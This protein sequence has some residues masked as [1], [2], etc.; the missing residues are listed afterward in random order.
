MEDS[1]I[2]QI[3]EH[4]DQSLKKKNAKVLLAQYGGAPDESQFIGTKEG[5]LRF[6]IEIMK[7]A[8]AKKD[9]KDSITVDLEY[10]LSDD[11]N[12][13]FEWFERRDVINEATTSETIKDKI[14][15]FIGMLVVFMIMVIIGAGFI[16]G[17]RWLISLFW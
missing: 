8:Y 11:S 12:V 17:I 6:G 9:E 15:S 13:S 1:E 7:A 3:I 2:K 14:T 4:L 16:N 10:L 5:Y